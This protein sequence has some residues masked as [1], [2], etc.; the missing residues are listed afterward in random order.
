MTFFA[1]AARIVPSGALLKKV[2]RAFVPVT[3]GSLCAAVTLRKVPATPN[4]AAS[5]CAFVRKAARSAAS[6]GCFDCVGTVRKLPPQ[7][8]APPGKTFAKSQPEVASPPA[9]VTWPLTT[10]SIQPGQTKV[11]NEPSVKA[12]PLPQSHAVWFDERPEAVAAESCV[13]SPSSWALPSTFS[14]PS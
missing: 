4:A 3:A 14:V 10:P 7:L 12:L 8:A 13:H 6:C 9:L 2:D 11:E 1:R 5:D